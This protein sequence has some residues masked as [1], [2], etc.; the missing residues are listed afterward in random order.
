MAASATKGL[1]ALRSSTGRP[2]AFISLSLSELGGQFVQF[3]RV[4]YKTIAVAL[5]TNQLVLPW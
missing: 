5:L 1:T 2:T 3:G 4:S